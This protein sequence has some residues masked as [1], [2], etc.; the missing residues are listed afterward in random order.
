MAKPKG[1]IAEPRVA[2]SRQA[3]E[4]YRLL[5]AIERQLGEQDARAATWGAVGELDAVNAL[6]RQAASI[7]AGK[8]GE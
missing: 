4:A 7:L 6:L 1:S 2:Y 3:C 8:G 5:E